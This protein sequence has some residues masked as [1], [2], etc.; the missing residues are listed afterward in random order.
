L[1]QLVISILTYIQEH[2]RLGTNDN[3]HELKN[4]TT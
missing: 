2:W 3:L 1:G 4:Y